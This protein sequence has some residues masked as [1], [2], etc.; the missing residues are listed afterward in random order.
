VLEAGR[1]HDLQPCGLGARDT[2][3]LEAGMALYGNDIDDDHTPL[4]AG[5]SWIVKLDK[6]TEFIGA[7]ALRAQK[8]AGVPRRLRGLEMKGRGIPRHDYPVLSSDGEKIGVVTS[9]TQAPY[10]A[11]PIAMAYVD[12]AHAKFGND[13]AVEIR[14]KG[15]DATVE[16]LPFYRRKKD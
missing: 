15:V 7:P 1:E 2:L 12:T 4:E 8:E 13:V 10:L 14:G 6:G 16:K 5:L 3:R 9:G 11:R